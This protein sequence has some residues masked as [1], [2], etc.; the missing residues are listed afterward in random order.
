MNGDDKGVVIEKKERLVTMGENSGGGYK[1]YVAGLVSGVSM[2][3][4]GHP[5]DTVKVFIF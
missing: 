2:V 4:V 3:I 5:F 1:H